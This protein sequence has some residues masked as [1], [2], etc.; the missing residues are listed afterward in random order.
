M[1][2]LITAPGVL[3]TAAGALRDVGD[4]IDAASA[5]AGKT[6]ASVVPP[7]RDEVSTYAAKQLCAAAADYHMVMGGGSVTL[8]LFL[9]ALAYGEEHYSRAEEANAKSCAVM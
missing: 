2:F 3:A 9:T 7:G 4:R 6:T 5:A 1:P 8:E